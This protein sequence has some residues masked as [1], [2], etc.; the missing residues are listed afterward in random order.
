MHPIKTI[1]NLDG[2]DKCCPAKKPRT[3]YQTSFEIATQNFSAYPRPPLQGSCFFTVFCTL[4]SHT[5]HTIPPIDLSI[6]Y[7]FLLG[8]LIG[9]LTNNWVDESDEKAEFIA[10][11]EQHFHVVVESCK[12]GVRKPDVA[13]FR[14]ACEQLKTDPQE[15]SK[16]FLAEVDANVF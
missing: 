10:L 14:I 5:R 13:A 6:Y 4:C 1:K 8:Y 11:L 12:E 9:I 3:Y 2:G 16:Q 15:V 7:C